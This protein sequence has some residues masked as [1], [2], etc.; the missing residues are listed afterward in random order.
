MRLR[1]RL[2]TISIFIVATILVMMGILYLITHRIPLGIESDYEAVRQRINTI[3]YLTIALST[4]IIA[5]VLIIFRLLMGKIVDPIEELSRFP[6]MLIDGRFD[7][8]LDVRGIEEYRILA[9][10]LQKIADSYK[11]KTDT[12]AKRQK[13]VRGLAILNELIGFITSEMRFDIIIKN[14]VDRAK[15]L[16]KSGY[17]AVVAFEPDSFK[18]KAFVT[19]EGIQDPLKVNLKLEGF[20][21]IPLNEHLPLRLSFKETHSEQYIKIPE[22]NLEVKDIL[23]VPL[24]F[25][26]KLGGLLLVANKLEGTFDQEDED[27]LMNFAFQAFQI[28]AMHEE[29][30]NLA[31]TDGLTGLNNHRHFQERLKEEVERTK[32]YGR[33]LSLL[34]LDIDQFKVFNDTYGHQAGDMVLRAI[35]SIISGEM[36]RTDFAARYGGEE[37]SIIL[38]ETGYKDAGVFAERIRRKIA[39]TPLSLLGEEKVFITVSIGFASMGDNTKDKNE[40][41]EM[42]D[43]ALY[44]AKNRGR[45]MSCGF[46]EE[47]VFSQDYA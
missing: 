37:F 13:V 9:T 38:P 46:E 21:K 32:R 39:E 47:K 14:F 45:N 28:I 24:I 36:R 5:G 1:H 27:I 3:L 20:F 25:A 29:I 42:A 8:R 16:I 7:G 17:C 4:M 35:A 11:E 33:E 31:L 10:N 43:R 18:V 12:I 30:T 15:Y 44:L 23:T 34:I 2:N 22:L 19:D 6:Q 40:L 26:G 41:I